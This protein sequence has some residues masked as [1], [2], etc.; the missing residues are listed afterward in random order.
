MDTRRRQYT[1]EF[2]RDAVA[3][4]MEHGY[5]ITVAAKNLGITPKLLSRWKGEHQQ[6]RDAAFPGQGHQM[7]EHAELRQLREENRRLRME[8]DILKKATAFF[9]AH[10]T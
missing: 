7:P 9:A 5:A 1:A 3:L 6:H 10:S 8:R 4:V 2:K